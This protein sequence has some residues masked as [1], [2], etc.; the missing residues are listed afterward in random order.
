[1]LDARIAGPL[2]D[3]ERGAVDPVD[4]G[5][6]CRERVGEREAA[7]IVAVPIELDVGRPGL[8]ECPPRECDES[9]RAVR[10]GAPDGVA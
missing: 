6:Q 9:R 4:S 10:I 7:I 8:G 5:L 1:M 3:A 2:T